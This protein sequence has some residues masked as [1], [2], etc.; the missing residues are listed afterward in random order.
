M[1]AA[2][3][4]Y[5]RKLQKDYACSTRANISK[6]TKPWKMP[7]TQKKGRFASCIAG[8][9]RSRLSTCMLRAG[10]TAARS[11]SMDEA[12]DGSRI[13]PILAEGF[14]WENY[15]RMQKQSLQKCAGWEWRKFLSS[16]FRC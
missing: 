16:I 13:G 11:K 2:I 8:Y 1:I 9:C 5:I 3:L 10:I 12:R 14:T 6:H 7:G 15:E 4:R